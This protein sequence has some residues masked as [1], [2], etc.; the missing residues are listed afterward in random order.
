MDQICSKELATNES[1]VIFFGIKQ[2]SRLKNATVKP[3]YRKGNKE[4]IHN[5][6]ST[7]LTSAL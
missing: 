1:S 4:N 6:S 3:P 7:S 5:Y 2:F